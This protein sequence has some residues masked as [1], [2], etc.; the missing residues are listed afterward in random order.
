METHS[1]ILDW[2]I[3]WTEEPGVLQSMGCKRV[4]HDLATKQEHI[5]IYNGILLSHFKED[6]I[7]P[8]AETWMNINIIILSEVSISQKNKYNI[9]YMWNLKYDTNDLIY[10]TETDSGIEMRC[11]VT[12][13][14]GDRRGMDWK[15]G[16]SR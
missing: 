5:N 16:A 9:T 8:F 11:V 3:L 14:A 2:G 10:E 12:K 15:F 1:S 13:G 4:R 7:M 6:E